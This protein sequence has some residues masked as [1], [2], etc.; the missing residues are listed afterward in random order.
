MPSTDV[1][2]VDWL[3]HR[4]R[5][6]CVYSLSAP[7]SLSSTGRA[8]G[9]YFTLG[10]R[11]GLRHDIM[12]ESHV[13]PMACLPTATSSTA[14][15]VKTTKRRA[16]HPRR[17]QA[18]A[19]HR[20]RLLPRFTIPRRVSRSWHA[21][22]RVRGCRLKSHRAFTTVAEALNTRNVDI[23]SETNCLTKQ[24]TVSHGESITLLAPR[25][26]ARSRS[27]PAARCI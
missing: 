26:A 5:R 9:S 27:A 4:Q 10:R 19:G 3:H 14:T 1:V 25:F 18:K 12:R 21:H 7:I 2:P 17:G 8:D 13:A 22:L 20:W 24:G 15:P 11:L 23:E 6:P 16:A